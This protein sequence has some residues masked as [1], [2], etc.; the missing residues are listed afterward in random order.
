MKTKLLISYGEIIS[1]E[2]L[3]AAWEE[4]LKGKRGKEDT[5]EPAPTTY[6]HLA[7][8]F[9]VTTDDIISSLRLCSAMSDEGIMEPARILFS[10][11]L[12]RLLKEAMGDEAY[13]L[14]GDETLRKWME[15]SSVTTFT[16]EQLKGW[17]RARDY[18]KNPR[19]PIWSDFSGLRKRERLNISSS[20]RVTQEVFCKS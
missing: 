7:Q 8:F 5:T 2:N 15:V 10:T 17:M 14:G 13:H 6:T 12:H 16:L 18:P 19:T 11:H 3:L 9:G 1:P 4:F 20:F